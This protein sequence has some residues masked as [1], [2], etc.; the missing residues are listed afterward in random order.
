MK[1]ETKKLIETLL[2]HAKG[3]LAAVDTW[4]KETT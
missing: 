2:R 3:M 1:P 4:L